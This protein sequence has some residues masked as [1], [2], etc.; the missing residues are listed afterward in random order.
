MNMFNGNMIFYIKVDWWEK[1]WFISIIL[2]LY[3]LKKFYNFKEGCIIIVLMYK[4]F[5]FL[6]KWDKKDVMFIIYVWN[7]I[8][9]VMFYLFYDFKSVNNFWCLKI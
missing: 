8:W 3:S 4:L 6:L 7:Y 2:C 5:L 9:K 1:K